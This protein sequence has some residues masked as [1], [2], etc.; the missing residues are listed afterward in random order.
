MLLGHQ[1]MGVSEGERNGID[2]GSG[3]LCRQDALPGY[4]VGGYSC[5]PWFRLRRI[6]GGARGYYRRGLAHRAEPCAP[7]GRKGRIHGLRNWAQG[8]GAEGSLNQ[9]R[10]RPC[11]GLRRHAALHIQGGSLWLIDSP[12]DAGAPRGFADGR[13]RENQRRRISAGLYHWGSKSSAASPMPSTRIIINRG[14]T[15]RRLWAGSARRWRWEK[16]CASKKRR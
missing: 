10:F 14:F 16:F 6:R 13:E 11:D 3:A 4:S 7:D 5:G 12:D 15:L 8:P 2:A 1:S 9:R